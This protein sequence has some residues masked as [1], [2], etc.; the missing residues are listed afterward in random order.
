M[1][2]LCLSG[3]YN[4]WGK[5]IFNISQPTSFHK[6]QKLKLGKLRRCA[7]S[8]FLIFKYFNSNVAEIIAEIFIPRLT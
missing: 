2:I 3:G 7:F 1:P 5:S 6:N 8:I 4:N